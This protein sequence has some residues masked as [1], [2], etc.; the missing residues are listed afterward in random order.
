MVKTGLWRNHLGSGERE[1]K[2]PG[3]K[4]GEGQ[5]STA[6]PLWEVLETA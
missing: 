1:V 5:Q 4:A 2:L 6:S 3:G